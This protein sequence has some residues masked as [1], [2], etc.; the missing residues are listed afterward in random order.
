MN[1]F[2][3]A[4][5]LAFRDENILPINAAGGTPRLPSFYSIATKI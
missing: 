2:L 3:T 4:P 5:K 1:R